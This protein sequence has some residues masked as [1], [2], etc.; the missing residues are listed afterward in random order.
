MKR[1]LYLI[2]SFVSRQRRDKFLISV[3]TIALA[4]VVC[5]FVPLAPAEAYES[6][7]QPTGYVNDFAEVIEPGAKIQLESELK[8][9]D[10]E[11]GHEIS[12]VTVNSLGEDYIENFA[13][14]LFEEWGVGKKDVDNGVLFLVAIDDREM[15]IEVGY[16]LEGALT[17]LQSKGILDSFAKPAFQQGDYTSGIV[18]SAQQ[19]KNVISGE[20]IDVPT[21]TSSQANTWVMVLRRFGFWGIVIVIMILQAV[22]VALGK[23]KRWWPGGVI[24]GGIGVVIG[25]I[26]W[27]LFAG[28]LGGVIIGGL[29]LILDFGASRKDWFKNVGKGGKGGPWFF[30]GGGG[31]GGGGGFGGFGGGFS[32]GG[33]ASGRW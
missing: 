17:D 21:S 3:T 25:L 2:C 4:T 5:F 23:S 20:V 14:K 33:G 13:V 15:R 6:P 12:V 10:A 22:G 31:K 28:I 1:L 8:S 19:I 11:T 29:G 30:G 18:S 16:G 7:G 26:K 27:S 9:F 24:G 32:G